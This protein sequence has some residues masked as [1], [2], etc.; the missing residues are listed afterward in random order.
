[1]PPK[2]VWYGVVPTTHVESGSFWMTGYDL[3]ILDWTS[4]LL[5]IEVQ[6]KVLQLPSN[7]VSFA[8]SKGGL[9]Q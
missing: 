2:V 8:W 4:R 3:T 7:L 1:M 6:S 5:V 9:D